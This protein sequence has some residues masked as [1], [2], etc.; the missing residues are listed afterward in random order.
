MNK[1]LINIKKD[2]EKLEEIEKLI[3]DSR[4][5]IK[6]NKGEINRLKNVAAYE[7]YNNIDNT[8]T[9]HRIY[10]LEGDSDFKRTFIKKSKIEKQELEDS[11]KLILK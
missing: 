2:I 9:K 7:K 1:K 3:F 10:M 5:T 11:L 4:D 8:S 6:W